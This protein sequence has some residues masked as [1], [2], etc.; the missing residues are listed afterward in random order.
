[1]ALA[2]NPA[3][4]TGRGR[5]DGAAEASDTLRP[6]VGVDGLTVTAAD[7]DVDLRLP[8]PLAVER[9]RPLP[10][11]ISPFDRLSLRESKVGK[12][13]ILLDMVLEVLVRFPGLVSCRP[14]AALA[15]CGV[16]GS[17]ECSWEV[18]EASGV[19]VLCRTRLPVALEVVT[20]GM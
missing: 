18:L 8:S 3:E 14:L 16:E 15:L 6:C 2:G 13:L 17:V 10:F 12:R 19:M 4:C 1:M 7:P 5:D 20:A 11:V 9:G